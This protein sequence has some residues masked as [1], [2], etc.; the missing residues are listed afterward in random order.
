M[1]FSEIDRI[2]TK[3]LKDL[4]GV[5]YGIVWTDKQTK[6][7]VI[8]LTYFG[9]NVILSSE[10]DLDRFLARFSTW[11]FEREGVTK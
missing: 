3:R 9:Q 10:G 7:G 11:G 2:C 1:K 8:D 6:S 5:T 4:E